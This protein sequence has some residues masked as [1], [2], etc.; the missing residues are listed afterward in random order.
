MARKEIRS[1]K[2]VRED[3]LWLLKK[4]ASWRTGQR[5]ENRDKDQCVQSRGPGTNT[6][7]S[8]ISVSSASFAR[9]V[10]FVHSGPRAVPGM[11]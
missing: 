11:E 5:K 3:R 4:R 2:T 10:A 7:D 8:V 1:A 6:G 9:G